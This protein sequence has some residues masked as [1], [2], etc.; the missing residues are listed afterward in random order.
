MDKIEQ[1]KELGFEFYDCE[2]DY[3][4]VYVKDFIWFRVKVWVFFDDDSHEV[5]TCTLEDDLSAGEDF[6]RELREVADLLEELEEL[7]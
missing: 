3:C 4:D 2:P 5:D 7:E 1:L 6:I